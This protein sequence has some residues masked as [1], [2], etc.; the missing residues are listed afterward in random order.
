MTTLA[1]DLYLLLAAIGLALAA[2]YAGLPILGQGAFVAVGAFGVVQLGRAGWPLGLAVVGAVGIAAVTGYAVGYGAARLYGA[3]LALATWAL[4]WLAY[5]VLVAFPSVSGGTQGLTRQSPARL[6]SPSLGTVVVLGPAAHVL[7]AG[8]LCALALAALARAGRGPGGLELAA[9]REGPA[10]ADSLGVPVARRRR[11]VLA[12]T[13]AVGATAGAGSAVLH[14]VVAPADY[15]PL[16]SLQLLAAVL[17][18]GTARWW[19]PVVGL[20]L[21]AAL[22]PVADALAAAAGT[23]P[24]RAGAALTALLLLLVLVLRRTAARRAGRRG[25]LAAPLPGPTPLDGPTR[26]RAQPRSRARRP[27]EG[28]ARPRRARPR[29]WRRRLWVRSAPCRTGAS[30]A[31]RCSRRAGYA[32]PTAPSWRWTGWT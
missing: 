17:I 26:R 25:L 8:L 18:G 20:A 23:D 7:I 4:A 2:S 30:R 10:I 6:V 29:S 24:S 28:A 1:G 21:L 12:T 16:L 11:A 19:G 3:S 32:S 9:L 22:P 15:S 27:L 14:G 31:R 5:A 13:A